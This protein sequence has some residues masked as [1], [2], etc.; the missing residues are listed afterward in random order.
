VLRVGEGPFV[1]ELKDEMG[2]ELQKKGG[3]FGVTTGRG[4]R[5]GWLDLVVV[6]HASRMCGFTSLCMTKLDVLND[7]PELPVCVAYEIDG[8][9]V[10][11][12]PASIAKLERAKPVY[13]TFKG[14]KG[15]KDTDSLVKGGYEN[16]PGEMREYI[17]F[18]EKYLK[19]PADLISVGPD[20]DET[21]DRKADWWN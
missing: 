3:E 18:I 6:E 16:L 21:I 7:I 19:V 20:R 13:E 14:W 12:F 15:W 10:R 1:S 9:E 8:Q 11:K 5:C 2:V 4:R 17:E